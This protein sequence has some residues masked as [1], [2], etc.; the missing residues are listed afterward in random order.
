MLG[1]GLLPQ[2]Q[3]QMLDFAD[4]MQSLTGHAEQHQRQEQVERPRWLQTWLAATARK[5]ATIIFCTSGTRLHSTAPLQLPS[6][7]L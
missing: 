1:M 6:G 5:M 2:M 4:Q 3:V 7:E